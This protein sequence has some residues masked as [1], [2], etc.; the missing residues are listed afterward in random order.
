MRADDR[1][2]IFDRN[3][4]EEQGLRRDGEQPLDAFPIALV[5]RRVP[6]P[7]ERFS[8]AEHLVEMQRCRGPGRSQQIEP[9]ATGFRPRRLDDL[10]KDFDGLIL[11]SGQRMECRENPNQGRS[12]DF[13]AR[14]QIEM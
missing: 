2:M 3:S 9:Q 11:A 1:G 6:M 12:R 5:M 14:F 8:V 10:P 13:N 4:V 7:A